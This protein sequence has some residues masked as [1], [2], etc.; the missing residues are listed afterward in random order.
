MHVIFHEQ[1]DTFFWKFCMH[2]PKYM[3]LFIYFTTEMESFI[4]SPQDRLYFPQSFVA[5]D[6]F[7][8]FSPQY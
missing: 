1:T 5:I 6:L 7:H 3:H 2:A 8:P 4:F